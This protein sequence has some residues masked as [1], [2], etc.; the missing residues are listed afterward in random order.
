VSFHAPGV[1]ADFVHTEE[2]RTFGAEILLIIVTDI[3]L[4]A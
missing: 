3:I 1:S 2:A 4:P